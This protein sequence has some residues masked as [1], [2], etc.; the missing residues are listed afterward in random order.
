MKIY[1][2]ICSRGQTVERIDYLKSNN[3][4]YEHHHVIPKCCNGID[5]KSNITYLTA[6]EHY[7]CHA[8][9]Y[10]ATMNNDEI[11]KRVQAQLA[12][13]YHKMSQFNKRQLG[14]KQ[15][16]KF[17][18]WDYKRLREAVSEACKVL[19]PWERRTEESKQQFYEMIKQPKSEDHRKKISQS[20]KGKVNLINPETNELI[21]VK[22]RDV[23]QKYLDSGWITAATRLARTSYRNKITGEIRYVSKNDPLKKNPDWE[24]SFTGY[25][26]FVNKITGE[27]TVLA[28]DD[29]R[30]QSDEWVSTSVGR[31]V[32]INIQTFETKCVKIGDI[33]YQE[34]LWVSLSKGKLQCK[35]KITG[36]VCWLLINDPRRNDP[37]WEICSKWKHE[38]W[39]NWKTKE[40]IQTN[41]KD[42][43]VQSNDWIHITPKTEF[44][45]IV[46][47]EKKVDVTI[48]WIKNNCEYWAPNSSNFYKLLVDNQT[49]KWV[50]FFRDEEY[51]KTIYKK[52]DV[53][54]AIFVNKQTNEAIKMTTADPRRND[55]N[56]ILYKTFRKLFDHKVK[57]FKNKQTGIVKVFEINK[58][59]V[60]NWEPFSYNNHKYKEQ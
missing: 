60:E 51:D 36:E 27:S 34:L 2:Q 23:V 26:A 47:L 8:L 38:I 49:Q 9:L 20:N 11:P 59:D 13:A 1:Q 7:I 55:K 18:S 30:R 48:D 50:I 12:Y 16:L 56:W 54:M 28:K 58:V 35:N 6:R 17:T 33:N 43:R 19:H 24:P 31:E 57:T 44:V 10:K 39:Y 42:D 25:A 45:N 52:Y 21:S 40:I 14:R 53:G 4:Y 37:N 46:T 3:I 15:G 32:R 29:P 22:G 41:F 5:D